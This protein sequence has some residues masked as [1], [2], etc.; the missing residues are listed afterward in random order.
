MSRYSISRRVLSLASRSRHGFTL[1]ELLVVIAIISMLVGLLMPAIQSA[2]E[3][4]RR[5]QCTNS[6]GQIVAAMVS[7]ESAQRTLPPGRMGCD[8]YTGSPCAATN[9]DA[10][11]SAVWDQRVFG[12]ASQP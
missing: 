7:Y 11:L 3:S 6:I 1:V 2:R 8:A 9:V 4:A 10:G 5:T 12:S